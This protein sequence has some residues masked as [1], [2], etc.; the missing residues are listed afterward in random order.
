MNIEV[1]FS[2][3]RFQAFI[4]FKSAYRIVFVNTV[5]KQCLYGKVGKILR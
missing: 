3:Y 2:V 4:I 5:R 1:V